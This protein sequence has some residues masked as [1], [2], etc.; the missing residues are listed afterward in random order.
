MVGTRSTGPRDDCVVV[1]T[2][3]RG[4]PH[5][6]AWPTQTARSRPRVGLR[7]VPDM[8]RV[9]TGDRPHLDGT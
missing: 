3:P 2:A 8:V 1:D 6:T 5:P 7:R 4:P 9:P